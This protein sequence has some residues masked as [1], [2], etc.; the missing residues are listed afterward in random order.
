MS[1]RVQKVVEFPPALKQA[2]IDAAEAD[3]SNM[4]D[5]AVA[6]LADEFGHSFAPTGKATPGITDAERTS[7]SMPKPLRR[8]IHVAAARRDIPALDLMLEVLCRY[9][10]VRCAAVHVR[11]ER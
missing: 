1:K 8:K 10:P 2:L 3:G 4:N 6:I 7:L 9:F 11:D 5:V